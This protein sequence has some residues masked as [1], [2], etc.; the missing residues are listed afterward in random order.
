MIA[1]L[2]EA[3]RKHI[4]EYLFIFIPLF[5]LDGS[6]RHTKRQQLKIVIKRQ[7]L[8]SVYQVNESYRLFS[9]VYLNQ[10]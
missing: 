9:S 3:K 1:M 8:N 2:I 5:I 7:Y 6:L 10:L 4:K